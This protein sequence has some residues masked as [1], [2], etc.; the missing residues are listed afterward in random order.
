MAAVL[1]GQRMEQLKAQLAGSS[2]A[3]GGSI[4][5]DEPG[6]VDRLGP[7]GAPVDGLA[8]PSY[9]RR[10]SITP[11]SSG[12]C[13]IQVSVTGARLRVSRP[14]EMMTMGCQGGL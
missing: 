3:A 8:A 13:V 6:F 14:A 10:W 9:I 5:R 7:D 4:E 1:A 12:L 2:P 11:H